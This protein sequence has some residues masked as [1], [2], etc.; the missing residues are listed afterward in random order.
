[1]KRDCMFFVADINMMETFKGFLTRSQFHKS[2]ECGPFVFDSLTDIRHAGGIADGL[3]IRVARDDKLS[4]LLRGYQNTHY[5]LVV[6]LDCEFDGSPRQT[7]IRRNLSLEL[8]NIGW[9][10]ADF[11]VLAIEPEL[12][13]WIWQ[14]SVHVE[15]ALKHRA[16]PSLREVLLQQGV[17]PD[18]EP[19]PNNPK[20]TL[21]DVVFKNKVRRSSAIYGE[22]A[23][24][25]S[26]KH[27][28][29]P[30]FQRLMAQLRIWFPAE[31]AT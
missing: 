25:V 3:H 30:E 28:V 21:K 4:L 18:G 7:V 22:I 23:R 8:Q 12:E 11:I 15:A 10:A 14:D 9:S 13:Q 1:M 29:D 19:K 20:E 24:K 2:I 6:A 17:W 26:V 16:P 31:G 5:K 27:C